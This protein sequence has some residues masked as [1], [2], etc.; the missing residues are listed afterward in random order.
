MTSGLLLAI[1]GLHAT[2][3]QAECITYNN[4]KP[5]K[6]EVGGP[7]GPTK[8]EAPPPTDV[9]PVD[10]ATAARDALGV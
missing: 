9:D 10:C 6:V 8:V 1:V 2:P 7:F 3:A 5:L 4:T